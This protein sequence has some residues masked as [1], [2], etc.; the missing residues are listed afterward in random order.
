MVEH[1]CTRAFN[2]KRLGPWLTLN[3]FLTTKSE[4]VTL[5]YGMTDRQTK[6]AIAISIKYAFIYDLLNKT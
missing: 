2:F 5:F 6:K 4:K 1:D 3:L